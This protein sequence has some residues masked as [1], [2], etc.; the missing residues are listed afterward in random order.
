MQSSDDRLLDSIREA[1]LAIEPSAEVVLYGSR[2]RGDA[3]PEADWDLL[4][5]LDGRLDATRTSAVRR[6]VYEIEWETG[7]VLS[8]IVRSRQEWESPTSKATPFHA[9]IEREGVRL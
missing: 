3:S 6:R 9:N 5:L 8:T 1:V 2:A 4:V 7:E